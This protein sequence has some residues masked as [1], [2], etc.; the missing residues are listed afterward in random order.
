MK[1]LLIFAVAMFVATASFAQDKGDL[2]ISGSIALDLGTQTNTLSSGGNS[3][4]ASQPLWTQSLILQPS[5][6]TLLLIR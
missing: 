5:V 6:A 1:K 4:S 2:F 3:V